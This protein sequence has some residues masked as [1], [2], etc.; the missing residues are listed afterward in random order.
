MST[1]KW[2]EE[3]AARHR[4]HEEELRQLYLDLY[5]GDTEAFGRL[6]QILRR[7]HK[8]RPAELRAL[9]RDRVIDSS[10]YKGH[11]LVGMLMYVNAF[12]GTLRGARE[13]L[14]YI[15]DCGVN[16]LHL[17]PLLESPEDRSDGGYAVSDFRRVQPGLGDMRDLAVLAEDCHHRGI[18]LCLDFVMNHTSEDHAWA[19]AALRRQERLRSRHRA[20]DGEADVWLVETHDDGVLGIGRYRQGEKPV[21]LYNFS[22]TEKTIAVDELGDYTNL[23]SGLDMNK[24]AVTVPSGGFVWM[25]CDFTEDEKNGQDR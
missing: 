23:L 12:A 9:D 14:D 17:M 7:T 3:F 24:A 20:F 5:H 22:E 10:W 19:K 25:I 6:V 18:A 8:E 16:Y 1:A 15:E 2:D 4:R 13:K 21:A 11:E